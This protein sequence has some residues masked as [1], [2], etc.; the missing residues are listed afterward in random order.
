MNSYLLVAFAFAIDKTLKLVYLENNTTH[1]LVVKYFNFFKF[2]YKML[3]TKN[4]FEL[5]VRRLFVGAMPNR[6]LAATSENILLKHLK[7]I[8]NIIYNLKNG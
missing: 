5:V 8:Y 6:C 4:L 3:I 2:I 1:L 7:I